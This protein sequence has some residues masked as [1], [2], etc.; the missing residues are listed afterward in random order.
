MTAL[1]ILA[2][3][4]TVALAYCLG[5]RRGVALARQRYADER[6]RGRLMLAGVT[7]LRPVRIVDAKVRL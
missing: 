1:L 3:P 7:A 4:L 5:R 2:W 6:V